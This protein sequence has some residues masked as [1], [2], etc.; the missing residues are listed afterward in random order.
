MHS[1]TYMYIDRKTYTC[2]QLLYAHSQDMLS[3][4]KADVWNEYT[5]NPHIYYVKVSIG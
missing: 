1:Y 5:L 2:I 4:S 3:H